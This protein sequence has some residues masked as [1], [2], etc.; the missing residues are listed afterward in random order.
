[1]SNVYNS[2]QLKE[3]LNYGEYDKIISYL[4]NCQLESI[5]SSNIISKTY[6]LLENKEEF[7][8]IIQIIT[9]IA[10]YRM[11]VLDY[12]IKEGLRILSNNK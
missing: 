4:N 1:M 2:D 11:R 12:E 6:S 8:K 10:K 9:N 3:Y 5:P 7:D